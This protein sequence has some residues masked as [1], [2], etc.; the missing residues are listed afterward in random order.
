VPGAYNTSTTHP[1]IVNEAQSKSDKPTLSQEPRLHSGPAMALGPQ[2]S[3]RPS[4]HGDIYLDFQPQRLE[5]SAVEGSANDTTT[6]QASKPNDANRNGQV[7]SILRKKR[8]RVQSISADGEDDSSFFD[9]L[10]TSPHSLTQPPSPMPRLARQP[11]RLIDGPFSTSLASF[12]GRPRVNWAADGDNDT[13]TEGEDHQAPDDWPPKRK[14]SQ[15][16]D[17]KDK[18]KGRSVPLKTDRAV[19]TWGLPSEP[20]PKRRKTDAVAKTVRIAVP[21]PSIS[22]PSEGGA[23]DVHHPFSQTTQ[24]AEALLAEYAHRY[25]KS[26]STTL[27]NLPSDSQHAFNQPTQLPDE[28]VLSSGGKELGSPFKTPATTKP[29]REDSALHVS[30]HQTPHNLTEA[31]GVHVSALGESLERP[32]QGHEPFAHAVDSLRKGQLELDI[33]SGRVSRKHCQHPAPSWNGTRKAADESLKAYPTASDGLGY[34]SP[35]SGQNSTLGGTPTRP[36]HPQKTSTITKETVDFVPGAF[37][38]AVRRGDTRDQ[39][40]AAD[41]EEIDGGHSK[42]RFFVGTKAS[43]SHALGTASPD[44]PF[45]DVPPRGKHGHQGK[46]RE[47]LTVGFNQ[48]HRRRTFGGFTSSRMSTG[49]TRPEPY[50]LGVRQSFPILDRT[51]SRDGQHTRKVPETASPASA[52]L[53]PSISATDQQLIYSEGLRSWIERMSENH[54]FQEDVTWRLWHTVADLKTVDLALKGMR[55]AAE[56]AAI[57]IVE[58]MNSG[59]SETPEQHH[60]G[61]EDANRHDS[62][63]QSH[64]SRRRTSHMHSPLHS[65]RKSDIQFTPSPVKGQPDPEYAPPEASRA[66]E[67]K[68]LV[69]QGRLK[70]ALRREGRRTSHSFGGVS[71]RRKGKPIESLAFPKPQQATAADVQ[72][73]TALEQPSELSEEDG[74]VGETSKTV[75]WGEDKDAIILHG[76]GAQLKA[77]EMQMG[78]HSVR[79]RTLQLLTYLKIV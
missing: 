23:R 35:D 24:A 69:K 14:L 45:I 15:D 16:V 3:P 48:K 51:M 56:K 29:R 1:E 49:T 18:G 8:R 72:Q 9:S 64:V 42:S 37:T 12:R 6:P 65:P 36:R 26:E 52:V 10:P 34:V 22:H 55:E 30:S 39:V 57:Q 75:G 44:D 5:G 7:K 38:S 53:P 20:A 73:A 17:K 47:D 70:E 77:L 41:I 71:F 27:Q 66:G 76:D 25:A 32:R 60:T 21:A 43:L 33:V 13:E 62:S 78:K 28:S 67:F 40:A 46:V 4:S 50:A 54:G 2:P 74:Q 58:G 61:K 79:Q 59:Q 31:L 63:R 11:P 68:R 19:Q